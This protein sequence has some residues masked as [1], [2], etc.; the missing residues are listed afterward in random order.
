LNIQPILLGQAPSAQGDGRPFTGPS[1]KT[2]C[3]WL[4]VEGREQ[5]AGYFY[6]EN[7]LP[8]PLPRNAD[9]RRRSSQ[10]TPAQARLGAN[11]FLTRTRFRMRKELGAQGYSDLIDQHKVFTVVV[12]G[13]KVWKGFKLPSYD[14]WF[15]ERMIGDDFM[16]IKFPHP[17]GLNHELND[18]DFARETA[19]RLRAIALHRQQTVD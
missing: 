19:S 17:S 13:T 4:G 16:L 9:E 11:N 15:T 12:L 5:L 6:L 10:L 1:G 3:K 8:H 14:A 7:L 18:P 2:V